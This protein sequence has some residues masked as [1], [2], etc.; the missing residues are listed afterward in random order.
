MINKNAMPSELL[1]QIKK[2]YV[3]EDLNQA[4]ELVSKLKEE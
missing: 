3:F 4:E 1:E 2:I